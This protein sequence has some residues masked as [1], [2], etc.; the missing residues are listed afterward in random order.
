[1][2][3]I[4]KRTYKVSKGKVR[5]TGYNDDGEMVASAEMTLEQF[6]KQYLDDDSIENPVEEK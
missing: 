2:S 4:T 1:M 5:L 3:T 6:K